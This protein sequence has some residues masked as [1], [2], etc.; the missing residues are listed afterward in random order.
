VDVH[1]QRLSEAIS[2]AS[3]QMN[4]T[5][6]GRKMVSVEAFRPLRKVAM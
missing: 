5:R 3:E 6:R 4:T 1:C 2:N